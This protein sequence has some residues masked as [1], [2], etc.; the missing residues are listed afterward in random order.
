MN[1]STISL[2]TSTKVQMP[3]LVSTMLICQWEELNVIERDTCNCSHLTWKSISCTMVAK[4]S[5]ITSWVL[6][7]LLPWTQHKRWIPIG[8]M[9]CVHTHWGML[10]IE[11]WNSSNRIQ[12][13][14][15]K[16][17]KNNWKVGKIN[18][19]IN[20]RLTPRLEH[21][22]IWARWVME[23]WSWITYCLMNCSN[24]RKHALAV[25]GRRSYVPLRC[26]KGNVLLLIRV[27][28]LRRKGC[29]STINLTTMIK[30]TRGQFP[31]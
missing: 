30:V 11:G 25:G 1:L 26:W 2:T 27:K 8:S 4:V 13:V 7:H 29:W 9:G 18:R 17:G 23:S 16:N 21:D 6:V 15:G 19:T 3:S 10:T 5:Q 20:Q 22:K 24:G 12:N 28:A 14:V 31:K